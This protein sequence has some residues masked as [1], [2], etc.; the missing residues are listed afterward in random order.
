MD[1]FLKTDWLRRCRTKF[2]CFQCAAPMSAHCCS[3]DH[4]ALHHGSRGPEPV[5]VSS[6]LSPRSINAVRMGLDCSSIGG[7]HGFLNWPIESLARNWV[8]LIHF[9]SSWTA[10]LDS[11]SRQVLGSIWVLVG[12]V[13]GLALF[14]GSG[15]F[16]VSFTL[17]AGFLA[18][19]G[20]PSA[21]LLRGAVSC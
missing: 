18:S 7:V 9:A 21:P 3:D 11:P 16:P 12:V 8:F 6:P 5:R 10:G 15:R 1:A 4:R 20:G 17:L 13:I 2:F 14:A 19:N